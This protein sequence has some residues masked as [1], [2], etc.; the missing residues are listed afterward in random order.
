MQKKLKKRNKTSI[1][2]IYKLM[3]EKRCRKPKYK[4]DLKFLEAAL[5]AKATLIT[6]DNGILILNLG[7]I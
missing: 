5:A 2:K 1:E 7:L 3:S 6:E 4:K